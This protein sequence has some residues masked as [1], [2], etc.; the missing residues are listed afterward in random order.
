M[1]KY[2]KLDL[3]YGRAICYSGYRLGQSPE[4]DIHPTYKQV[5]E[6]LLIL[7]K[8]WEYLRLY[9]C[10]AHAETVLDVI[11]KEGLHFKVMLGAFIEAEM[12]NHGCPWGGI[13]PEKVLEEN[14]KRNTERIKKLISMA[15]TYPDII[16]FTS[17]GN[18]ATVEWTDHYV[19][20]ERIIG[21]VRML[22]RDTSQA[23]TFCENYLPWHNKLEPLV[24]EIDFISIH[25]YPVWEHKNIGEAM[26]YTR[27]NFQGVAEKYPGKPVI[28][29]E[30]GW[31]TGSNGRGINPAN[32]GED[33]QEIY[34][35]DLMKW[36]DDQGILTFFFEAFDEPWKGHPDELE[37]EKHWG[38]FY[39]NRKP[40]K[41]MKGIYA[42]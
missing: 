3:P 5:K 19:P 30:A 32:V 33:F 17:A 40:K 21:F 35:H 38:I 25:T 20:V 10:N 29:T 39:E 42:K 18:E 24:E 15:N 7:H 22:K 8:R 1:S 12:N 16:S 23:V 28:I 9:D 2:I 6:D 4:Q 11:R 41:V 27:N 36:A 13:Y 37:P 14:R 34:Y 26:K 31:A